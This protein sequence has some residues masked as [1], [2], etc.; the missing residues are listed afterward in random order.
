MPGGDLCSNVGMATVGAQAHGMNLALHSCSLSTLQAALPGTPCSM[1]TLCTELCA[2]IGS[3]AP[4]NSGKIAGLLGI[5]LNLG[6][7]SI[8]ASSGMKGSSRLFPYAQQLR[9]LR[10]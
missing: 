10:Q 1:G 5:G 9:V 4:R 6:L 2:Q 7:V 3:S 8:L